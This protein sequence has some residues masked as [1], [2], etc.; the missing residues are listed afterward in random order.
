M[1]AGLTPLA[2]LTDNA[3]DYLLV[4]GMICA[5][6]HLRSMPVLMAFCV[7]ARQCPPT[8]KET[9]IFLHRSA[10]EFSEKG[11]SAP[12]EAPTVDVLE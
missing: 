4:H 7:I 8:R 9:E 10:M 1:R 3:S 11:H 12:P 2:R 6:K 5:A